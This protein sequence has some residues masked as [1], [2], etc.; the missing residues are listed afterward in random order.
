VSDFLSHGQMTVS[1]GGQVNNSGSFATFGGGSVTTVAAGGGIHLGGSGTQQLGRVAGGL[2]VNHGVVNGGRLV[3]DFGG[4]VG[5]TGTFSVLPLAINGGVFSP[6]SSPGEVTIEVFPLNAGASYDFEINNATGAAGPTG[7]GPFSGWDLTLVTDS[8]IVDDVNPATASNP[9]V[10]RLKTFTNP[11][12]PDVAGPMANFDQTQSYMWLAFDATG[13]MMD[14]DPAVIRLD[15]TGVA[16]VASG[17]FGLQRTGNQI[18]VTYTPVPEPAATLA[19][20]AVGLAAA[21]RL[22]RCLISCRHRL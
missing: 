2:L 1:S 9:F 15:R 21:G 17:E 4:R 3:V 10:I 12:P 13:A 7:A 16:N 11:S 5:G 6:G 22:R 18:F 8:F 20:L 19:V 14:Y